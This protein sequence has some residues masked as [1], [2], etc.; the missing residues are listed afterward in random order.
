MPAWF[1]GR[2]FCYKKVTKK[3]YKPR[4]GAQGRLGL[5][6]QLA[7]PQVACGE[8]SCVTLS[9]EEPVC[10]NHY[11][12]GQLRRPPAISEELSKL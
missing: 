9:A 3:I 6:W 10:W 5:V 1:Y 2:L 8:K 12:H 7:L 11:T 4:G